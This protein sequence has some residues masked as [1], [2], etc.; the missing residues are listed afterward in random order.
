MIH[1]DVLSFKKNE[2]LLNI[3]VGSALLVGLFF[4]SRFN[5]LLF[6]GLAELFSIAVTWSVFLLVWSTRQPV[7]NDALM[8]LGISYLFVGMLDLVHTLAYKGTGFFPFDQAANFATQLWVAGRALEALS[9]L[10]FPVFLTR[11]IQVLYVFI[12]LASVTAL[13]FAAIFTWEIFPAC[14]IEGQGLTMFKKWAEYG[15]CLVLTL[16]IALLTRRREHVDV[17]VFWLMIW[18]MGFAIAAELAFTFYVSVY[19]LSNVVGHFLK[20]IS[21]FFVYLALIRSSLT[22]PYATLYRQLEQ[23]KLLHKQHRELLDAVFVSSPDFFA[24][25]D[26]QLKFQFVNPAFCHYLG[27]TQEEI[28]GKSDYELFSHN[29]AEIYREND[30]EVIATGRQNSGDYLVTGKLGQRWLQVTRTPIRDI[31]GSITSILGSVT[32]VTVRKQNEMVMASRFRLLRLVGLQSLAELLRSTLDEVEALTGSQVGFYHFVHADQTTLSL[33]AWSTN[34]IERM[35]TA[36]GFG[37]HYPVT[38][39][40][41]WVDCIHERGPVIHNDYTSLPHRKGMPPGHAPIIRELVVPVM[42]GEVIVAIL[43]VGNKQTDYDERDV[44][45]VNSL[46]DLAWD[47]AESKRSEEALRA[48]ENQFKTLAEVSPSGIWQADLQGNNTYVSTRWSEI[49]GISQEESIGAGWSQGIHPDDRDEV[50]RGWLQV[51]QSAEAHY[52]SEFRFVR[53]DGKVVWVLCIARRVVDPAVSDMVSWVG[54]ITDITDSKGTEAQLQESLLRYELVLDGASGGIWDWDVPGKKVHF[55]S[56]WKSLRGYSD[57]DIGDSELEWSENIHPDDKPLVLALVQAHL[58]GQAADFEAEYRIRCKDG[59]WKWVLDRG[60]AVRDAAGQVIRMAGS[61]IDITGKKIVEAALRES[62]SRFRQLTESLPLLVWSCR[63]DGY[64]DYLGRQWV[65]YTGIPEAEQ[66]GTGW[67][68]QL[69]PDDR[70]RVQREWEKAVTTGTY[71]DDE[72]RIRGRDGT[73]RWFKT[74]AIPI[75]DQA[76]NLLR[77]YGVNL[78]IEDLK[79][80]EDALEKRLLALTLPLESTESIA[81]EELF[82]LEDIQRLQD[83][84]SEATGVASIITRP[85]GALITRPSNFSRL[86][87]DIIRSSEQGVANCFVSNIA[88]T[89]LGH[90]GPTIRHCLSSGLWDAGAPIVISGHHVASWL[91]GQVRDETLNE[92]RIR[93]FAQEAGVDEA[94]AVEAF[95]EVPAM[96][97]EHF[98]KITQVLYTLAQQLS[99]TAY[100][101]VQQARFITARNQ[102]E[103]TL[104]QQNELLSAIRRAQNLFISGH[105]PHKVFMEI[106]NIL[107]QATGSSYGFLDEVLYQPDGNPYKVNLA[108]SDI[109]W[110]EKSK[111]LYVQL[112]DRK[113]EFH[114]LSNLAGAPVIERRTVIANDPP[115]HPQSLGVP[116]GHPSLNSF[117]GIP[118][119]YGEELIGVAG[120]ANRP[121]GYTEDIAESIKPLTQACAAMIWADSIVRREKDNL[122]ALQASEEK[123][124][125]MVETSSEGVWSMDSLF[126]ATYVNQRMAEMLGYSPGEMLGCSVDDFIFEEDFADHLEQV[127]ERRKGRPGV[128]E[129]RLRHKDGS[130]LWVIVAATPLHD[131]L[132]DF[133]GSFSMVTDI[134]ARKQIE[135]ALFESEKNYRQVVNTMQETLSVI[136]KNG[137]VVFLNEKAAHNLSRDRVES[138]IGNNILDFMPKEQCDRLMEDINNVILFDR[139]LQQEVLLSLPEGEKWFLST[140]QPIKFGHDNRNAVLTMS[141]DITA[142]ILAE[143]EQ[144]ILQAQLT[145]AQKMES[146]GRLAGG[147]AHDFN[148][149]L[150]AILGYTEVAQDDVDPA[151]PIHGYLE[152]IRK[153]AVRSTHLTRQLLAFARKQT[154][155]PQVLDLNETVAGMLNMLRR[156]IGEDINLVWLPGK[157]LWPV[158]MD[159]SQIDQIMANLC[160][161]ARDAIEGVGQITL[162]TDTA[163]FDASY[164]AVHPVALAGE[165]VSLTVSDDGCGMEQGTLDRIFEPFFTTKEIGKGTGLGLSTVFGIVQQNNGFIDV[166][167]APHMGTTFKIYL[168]RYVG[169]AEQ[170]Q[171]EESTQPTVPGHE[172][173]LLVED[174]SSILMMTGGMLERMGYTVLSASTPGEAIRLAEMH[175]GEIHL[176]ITDVIMPEMN[177]RDLAKRL[178]SFYPNLKRLFMSGYPADVIV[179]HGVLE[180]GINFIQKPFVRKD[181]AANVQKALET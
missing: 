14:Y 105:E 85:D 123:F 75:R 107:V 141:L 126:R 19:G 77:W 128:Y 53:P 120:V 55:S 95:H 112:I 30:R 108:L 21:F 86:C 149:M 4:I 18:A 17:E 27:R 66:I 22:R 165:F 63:P 164:C 139:P 33:Q 11:R 5:F 83:E 13:L 151:L 161:N 160:V 133:S 152:E 178:L 129:R 171:K 46:A 40:G 78:D 168:P 38:Q 96:S 81:F 136:D 150:G 170:I 69:H 162:G 119:F 10:L 101:N 67:A 103:A 39:A 144:E 121:D 73:H 134:T 92:E 100:Q 34:T 16:A 61:E 31:E 79:T 180:P 102:A 41:V 74:R 29:E 80:T 70:E 43:G 58:S 71:L 93:A 97:R 50:K 98:D 125:I 76:G 145:Q 109:S 167:S 24:L 130:A 99:V 154:V 57:S 49:T 94:M 148:N 88:Q 1:T 51:A 90:H 60:K 15:I 45:V 113:M 157:E 91:V 158:K 122:A 132:G 114:N 48:S 32:D 42:R 142:R 104:R 3:G 163:I 176:L 52:K 56:R 143:K 54:T 127:A 64:C 23:E 72:F 131:E 172:T 173:I 87:R 59:S 25:K 146:V 8:F 82:N 44:E 140:M 68:Q 36:E 177:G 110:D 137:V 6:H 179:H 117:M 20:I 166:A 7:R 155:S 118:L 138:V 135:K 2:L 175:R 12:S 159:P 35:C 84:F 124:R 37:V 147:V 174:E 153:A 9:L 116:N 89:Q 181:L 28:I 26:L 106:L 156:I 115:H 65:D 169:K 111:N 62:E 47:I